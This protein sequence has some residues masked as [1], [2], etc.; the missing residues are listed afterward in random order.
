MAA[1]GGLS[2]LHLHPT[3]VAQ[4]AESEVPLCVTPLT[5]SPTNSTIQEVQGGSLQHVPPAAL[6]RIAPQAKAPAAAVALKRGDKRVKKAA[7]IADQLAR[8]LEQDR[9]CALKQRSEAA[10]KRKARA[11]EERQAKEREEEQQRKA[12]KPSAR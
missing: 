6:T 10:E 11:R 3:I 9:M 7:P 12:A 4:L 8:Q 2:Y 5:T 1:A